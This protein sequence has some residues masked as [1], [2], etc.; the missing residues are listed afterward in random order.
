MQQGNHRRRSSSVALSAAVAAACAMPARG[1][2]DASWTAATSG[3]WT[4]ASR[5]S[6]SPVFPSN[7]NP[8]G[9]T[10]DALIDA[11]GAPY[12]VRFVSD[13]TLDSLTIDSPD[14]TFWHLESTG[15]P[16]LG[17][18][19][20][21]VLGT[22]DV[23]RGNYVLSNLGTI[24]N[25]RIQTGVG[26]TFTLEAFGSNL[27]AVT[28][29]TNVE[30]PN[31]HQLMIRNG[32]TLDNA[33]IS[34]GATG[35]TRDT[36][37]IGTGTQTLGGTGTVRFDGGDTI[38][39][40]IY[41]TSGALTL[42]PNVTVETGAFGGV[43]GGSFEGPVGG[44]L[45][46]QGTI[47]SRTPGQTLWMLGDWD[48]NGTLKLSDGTLALGGTFTP[49]DIGTIDR[50]GGRLIVAG[51]VDNA[52]SVFQASAA[53]GAIEL[54]GVGGITGPRIVGGVVR[55]N[56]TV[57][58][59][60]NGGTLQDVTVEGR[61]FVVNGAQ[62]NGVRIA[63]AS[64]LEL[65]GGLRVGAGSAPGA[66]A[67]LGGGGD[68][69]LSGGSILDSN[70]HV[71]LESDLTIRGGGNIQIN[72]GFTQRSLITTRDGGAISINSTVFNNFF[73]PWRNE[74]VLEAT[75]GGTLTL[76]GDIQ[77][78]GLGNFS[79]TDGGKVLV[80]GKLQNGGNTITLD[81]GHAFSF[82]G[83]MFGGT[84]RSADGTR[85]NVFQGNA[86]TPV[87]SGVVA[88]LDINVPNFVEF[89]FLDAATMAAGRKVH[90]VGEQNTV[91][92]GPT[93]AGEI[94]LESNTF[95][96]SRVGSTVN[97]TFGPNVTIRTAGGNG[98]VGLD[99]PTFTTDSHALLSA[100]TAGNT[101]TV[102]GSGNTFNNHGTMQVS[103]GTFTSSAKLTNHNLID[104]SGGTFNLAGNWNSAPGTIN[105]TGGQ[106]NLAGVF[107]TTK[108][109]TF[110]R[111]GGAVALTGTFN[112]TTGTTADLTAIVGPWSA[113]GSA[114]INGGSIVTPVP[115]QPLHVTGGSLTANNTSI[116]TDLAL[117]GASLLLNG[118]WDNNGTISGNGITVTLA[119]TFDTD[120][121]GAINVTNS[122]VD[123][124][125]NVNNVGRT[126]PVAFGAGT[127]V[128]L[129]TGGKVTGGTVGQNGQLLTIAGGSVDGVTL[130]A[131]AN[132][133]AGS[134][135]T[136]TNGLTLA[137][138]ATVALINGNTSSNPNP[139]P[140]VSPVLN[141]SGGTQTLGGT[142]TVAFEGGTAGR[143][144]VQPT[145]GGS[146]IIGSNVT[147]RT[148]A[149]SGF[150]GA[151]LR[152]TTNQGTISAG[153][154]G[155][156]IK[157]S[158]TIDNQG[159]IEARNGGTILPGTGF[160]LANYSAGTLT[161]GSW[162]AHAGSS[163][164]MGIG[165]ITV[166]DARVTL[167]G[168]GSTF[169]PIDSIGD[170]RGT[171]ALI[172][173]RDFTTASALVN[174]GRLTAGVGSDLVVAGDLTL[175]DD[176]VLAIELQTDASNE[177]YG[178]V[179]VNGI[180]SLDGAVDALFAAGHAVQAG[181][182]YTI[183]TAASITGSFDELLLPPDVK[184]TLL[185]SPASVQLFVTAVPE[186]ASFG[187]LLAL[188]TLL[189]RR[190]RKH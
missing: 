158:G 75:D 1:G 170:N 151:S 53:T 108:F 166:N 186:P 31:Q 4:D 117:A 161:G 78:G 6:T 175:G 129:R 70:A 37:V 160:A 46:N 169:A 68:V 25:A 174:T 83:Q 128:G 60:M 14:A 24:R 69:L 131:N 104:V 98:I 134:G 74:G 173:T 109:G 57:P 13:V 23:R 51:I 42:G 126:L 56:E 48:N 50:T 156:S 127:N 168:A 64:V 149:G 105:L 181:D 52:G 5:W 92:F 164:A 18:G 125:G 82:G 136:V 79:S 142:G 45:V 91:R 71:T 119:G 84:I 97:Q 183:L 40:A 138:G 163:I 147:I 88:D 171:F 85:L 114:V 113:S 165:N 144:A 28:L 43:V 22:I 10:Y 41:S 47:W 133:P 162:A 152:Q 132:I 159:T 35:T 116:D 115:G 106:L 27:D 89:A 49:A 153:T 185:Y 176:A 44:S 20:L 12:T 95:F 180:A 110:T 188:T 139:T 19:I 38:N 72:N 100:E 93:F 107:D 141:F 184:G 15:V 135:A 54:V 157:L 17:P 11:A 63:P 190:R 123:Y 140:S 99:G 118:T 172:A 137:G 36:G 90:M 67:T 96:G 145:T 16:P 61:G 59:T 179:A 112:N 26:G 143:A 87:L 101:L 34:V 177:T 124:V 30:V 150:V 81:A 65:T 154:A 182:L 86:T 102:F 76:G 73:V 148:G 2:T 80:V 178:Q 187:S 8:A 66:A 120:E 111:T 29:A 155:Q 167:S 77:V 122:V 103:A 55:G 94:L 62:G 189:Y 7:G 39:N 58:L 130:A 146:L 32:L 121:I 21:N 3:N 33:T 9:T